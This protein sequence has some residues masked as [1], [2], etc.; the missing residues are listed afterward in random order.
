MSP[1]RR[2]VT[3]ELDRCTVR[4]WRRDDATALVSHADDRA[5]WRNLRDR[6]PH[7]YAR[8]DAREFIREARR[9]D[10]PTLFAIEIDGEAC[11]GVGIEPRDDVDRRTAEI[12]YWVGRTHWNRGVATEAV[13]AIV[14]YAFATFDLVRL[15]ARVYAWNPASG[16]VLEKAGFT[17]EARLRS[18]ITKDG[19]TIDAF[20]YALVRT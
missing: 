2:P 16:R 7:P 6:F 8:R 14:E 20:L 13:R 17:R 11:G 4:E 10:P 15:E 9:H 19:E 18:A 3:F 1:G 5:V 12:G